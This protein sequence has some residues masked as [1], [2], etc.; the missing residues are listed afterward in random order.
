MTL[1][2]LSESQEALLAEERRT[3]AGLRDALERF[4]APDE[5]RRILDRVIEQLDDFFLL[6]VVGEFNAGKS[7]FINT[8]IGQDVLAEG[9]TPTTAQ[10]TV[11]RYGETTVQTAT[12]AHLVTVSAPVDLLRDVH[13]VDTPGTNAVLPEHQTITERFVPRAD[14]VMFLTSVDRPFTESERAFLTLI[15]DWG[16]KI[17]VVLNKIDIL[18]RDEQIAEVTGFVAENAERLVGIKPPVFAVSLRLAR[19]GR[20]GDPEAWTTSRFAALEAFVRE[21]LENRERIRLKLSSPLGVGL[22]LAESLL[23]Q[24]RARLGLLGDDLA[25]LEDV[26]RQLAVY[27]EDMSRD[28]R[29]RIA[30]IDNLLLAMEQ[31]GHAFFD[32]TLRVGRVFDLLNRSRIQEAFKREV[33]A[34]TPEQIERRVDTLIDWLVDADF[35]QWQAV[36]EH[37]R[38]RRRQHADRIV[39]ESA[40]FHH[41]RARLIDSVARQSQR[42]VDTYDRAREAATIADKA[43]ETVAAAAALQVAAA[44]LGAIVTIAATTAAAD[45]TGI[46]LAGVLAA[47]G[48]FVIPGRRHRAKQEMRQKI[49]LLREQLS[50]ALH[51]Q[52]ETEIRGSVSRIEESI[53]PYS[54]FVRAE[55]AKLTEANRALDELRNAMS[56]LRAQIEH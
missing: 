2:L 30:D 1:R 50:R 21:T 55:R 29:F 23:E 5:D 41:D 22:R 33:V 24:G 13:L 28:F 4:G 15:R 18:E 42:V 7:A 19:R 34:D 9:V 32:E 48:F 12:G 26:G 37:L 56:S 31:R 38:E 20:G 49:T 40:Q 17:I 46:V 39:G 14:L 8:L 53:A 6:V 36:N 27:R 10:I 25:V 11:L 44:G 47:V 35:R 54:R 3:L 16:K 52:F 51:Q 43:R 45:I